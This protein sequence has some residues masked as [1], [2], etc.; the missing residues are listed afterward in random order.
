MANLSAF[1]ISLG[2]A[3][4][5]GALPGSGRLEDEGAA[6]A[7][8]AAA[9]ANQQIECF[10][11]GPYVDISLALEQ[12]EPL[13]P[14]PGPRAAARGPLGATPLEGSR[15]AVRSGSMGARLASVCPDAISGRAA[16]RLGPGGWASRCWVL[17]GG[18][19]ASGGEPEQIYQ[20]LTLLAGRPAGWQ[21]GQQEVA[22]I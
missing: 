20:P 15:A 12:K 18:G 11:H 14:V 3:G 16:C 1:I 22:L 9:R 17:L 5:S 8:A 10:A 7:A 19:P 6:A 13:E 2:S 4:R 21:I